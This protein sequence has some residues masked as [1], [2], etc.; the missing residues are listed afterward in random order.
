MLSDSQSG[1]KWSDG[2]PGSS[3]K[4]A[5]WSIQKATVS[6]PTY[7][8]TTYTGNVIYAR[9]VLAGYDRNIMNCDSSATDAG[10]YYAT[11]TLSNSNYQFYGGSS[12]TSVQWGINQAY[13]YVSGGGEFLVYLNG[14]VERTLTVTFS[15]SVG[16]WTESG[17][18]NA[19]AYATQW[20]GQKYQFGYIISSGGSNTQHTVTL[21]F[22]GTVW[23]END[24]LND[25][26]QIRTDINMNNYRLVGSGLNSGSYV[27][28]YTDSFGNRGYAVAFGFDGTWY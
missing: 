15:K 19:D 2:A 27:T 21:K 11:V 8:S 4:S 6:A 22:T 24:R 23:N 10:T 16:T 14:K 5:S 17:I 26:V 1:C 20:T 18:G 7:G 9:D 3:S 25:D 13:I 12:S 28:T